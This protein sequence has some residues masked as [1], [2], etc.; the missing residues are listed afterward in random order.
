MQILQVFALQRVLILR[1]A[2]TRPPTRKSCTACRIERGAGNPRK[3][4]AQ[5][6]DDLVGGDLCALERLQ[7]DEHSRRYCAAPAAPGEADHSVDRRI[8][9]TIF[10]KLREL[11]AHR[12]ERNVLVGLNRA[13]R[14]PVSCCGKNPLGTMTYR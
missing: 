6:R 2:A 8:L 1:V 12:L 9:R 14:R 13:D 3:L 4:A 11:S 10:A 7:S 5:P